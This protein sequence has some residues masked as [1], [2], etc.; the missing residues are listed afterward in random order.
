MATFTVHVPADIGDPLRRADRTILVREGFNLPAFLF[1]PLFFVYRRLWLAALAWIAAAV[2][3]G[4]V[5]RFLDLSPAAGAALAGLLALLSG[6]EANEIRRNVLA[7]R[8]YLPRALITGMTR[9]RAER[10]FFES[11]AQPFSAPSPHPPAAMGTGRGGGGEPAVIGLFPE[12]GG[13]G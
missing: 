10:L 6:L 11:M 12:P 1:G 7:R 5:A 8:G 3:L 13:A 9:E 2:L 4:L